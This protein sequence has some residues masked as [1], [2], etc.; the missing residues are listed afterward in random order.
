MTELLK[1]NLSILKQLCK[2]RSVAELYAFGSAVSG[3]FNQQSDLDFAVVFE[4]SLSPLEKGEAF[5][6]LKDDLENLFGVEVDLISYLA[7]KNPIFR[8]ELDKTKVSLYAA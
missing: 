2:Q 5:F 4:A 3:N 8:S 1:S 6:A 7:L